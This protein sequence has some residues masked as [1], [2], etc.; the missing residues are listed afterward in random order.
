MITQEAHALSDPIEAL[1]DAIYRGDWARAA[2]YRDHR[3]A[4]VREYAQQVES[5]SPTLLTFWSAW[6]RD[7]AEIAARLLPLAHQALDTQ[8]GEALEHHRQRVIIDW[9]VR[10][11]APTWLAL[12]DDLVREVAMLRGLQPLYEVTCDPNELEG[13]ARELRDRVWASSWRLV[14]GAQGRQAREIAR[15]AARRA[16]LDAGW[17]AI[18]GPVRTRYLDAYVER[19]AHLGPALLNAAR[20]IAWDAALNVA[21]TTAV[22]CIGAGG[23][24]A[25][26]LAGTVQ[27]LQSSGHEVMLRLITPEAR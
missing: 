27:R 3:D 23:L 14:R 13:C 7:D 17:E 4:W 22:A 18:F 2:R 1:R 8:R 20:D 12:R 9:L 21:R 26:P 5:I 19:G 25:R 11:W 10:E 6:S 15:M 24:D 16:G